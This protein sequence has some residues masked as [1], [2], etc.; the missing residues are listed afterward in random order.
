LSITQSSLALHHTL[1]AETRGKEL[2]EM[3]TSHQIIINCS[4]K[5][6]KIE[7]F[8]LLPPLQNAGS[9]NNQTTAGY[10]SKTALL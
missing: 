1:H 10:V 7:E 5:S 3:R 8:L 6:Y 2:G 9:R 4:G